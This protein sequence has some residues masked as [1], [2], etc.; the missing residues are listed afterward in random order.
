M[1]T[2][3]KDGR[4]GLYT[5]VL[6]VS[7]IFLAGPA[8]THAQSLPDIT[9]IFENVLTC[10]LIKPLLADMPVQPLYRRDGNGG[11]ETINPDSV[12]PQAFY[13]DAQCEKNIPFAKTSLSEHCD[14]LLD[15]IQLGEGLGIT[16]PVWTLPPGARMDLGARS[17]DGVLQPYLQRSIYRRVLTTAGECELEMRVYSSHPDVRA[18]QSLLALHGGSW[19]GRGFGFLG[20]ELSIPHYVNEGFVVY[21]P[22]YRLLG[23]SEG[24]AAC[25]NASIEDAIEDASAALQWVN[26]NAQQY[27]SAANPVLFGQSAGAHLA[28]SLAIDNPDS[29][30]GSVL[31]YP[32]TDFTDF[33][34]RAQQGF[35]SNTQGLDILERVMG[36]TAELADIN[37]ARIVNNSF[38]IRI[39]QDDAPFP[40]VFM[41]H[42]KKDDLVEPRQSV[43]LCQALAAEPLINTD[44]E[45]PASG[46]LRDIRRCG[47]SSVLQLIEQGVHALDVCLSNLPLQNPFCPSGSEASRTEVAAAIQEGVEFAKALAMTSGGTGSGGAPVDS[48]GTASNAS[49]GGAALWLLVFGAGLLLFRSAAQR[50]DR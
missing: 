50:S 29:L 15:K 20:L 16:S 46:S 44:E 28:A 23:D 38:P 41:V 30:L 47:E 49:S 32:P 33:A 22:F 37:S 36:V 7:L 13:S 21:A 10:T 4:A 6:S 48:D 5:A 18:Q 25:R 8:Q 14:V 45:V 3:I 9:D 17:L 12:D 11:C 34:L 35:Y 26:D 40:P 42:G 24:S 1:S 39:A 31:F 19:S 43:R 2:R 27:G